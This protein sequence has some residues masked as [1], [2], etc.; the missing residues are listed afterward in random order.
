MIAVRGQASTGQLSDEHSL[1]PALRARHKSRTRVMDADFE[2]EHAVEL[3]EGSLAHVLEYLQQQEGSP[4][5]RPGADDCD[6]STKRRHTRS[7][8]EMSTASRVRDDI[9]RKQ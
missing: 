5:P 1:Q 7:R 6:R 4:G 2:G 3:Q 9:S 8:C